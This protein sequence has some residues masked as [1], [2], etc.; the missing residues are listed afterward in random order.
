MSAYLCDPYHIG[1]LAAFEVRKAVG[2]TGENRHYFEHHLKT[3]NPQEWAPAIAQALA[4]LNLDSVM[5]R[6]PSDRED[7]TIDLPGPTFVDTEMV[8]ILACRAAARYRWSNDQHSILQMLMACACYEYQSS[9]LDGW[10]QTPGAFWLNAIRKS[11][12]NALP[13]YEDCGGWG[14]EH[15]KRKNEEGWT[16]ELRE[17]E[18]EAHRLAPLA[19][20][21]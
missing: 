3:E 16:K 1:R 17:V 11:L 6:Y 4:R 20:V 9:E 18:E 21:R 8:Y 13:G 19:L 5:A 2:P 7:G 10:E 15:P 12:I 14:L